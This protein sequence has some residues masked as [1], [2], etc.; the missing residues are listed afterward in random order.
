VT[1]HPA[2]SASL[3]AAKFDASR[4]VRS[5]AQAGAKAQSGIGSA[6]TFGGSAYNRFDQVRIAAT[7]PTTQTKI[8]VDTATA[9]DAFGQVGW[10][11]C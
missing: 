6:S 2:E 5:G 10:R 3:R 11:M 4:A 7:E 1:G 9:A 8:S